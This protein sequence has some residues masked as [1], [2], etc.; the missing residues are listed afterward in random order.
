MADALM[1]Y[2]QEPPAEERECS[3]TTSEEDCESTGMIEEE[4]A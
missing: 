3:I 2:C 1:D 4:G